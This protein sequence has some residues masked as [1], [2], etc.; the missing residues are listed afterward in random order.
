MKIKLE[1]IHTQPQNPTAASLPLFLSA[2]ASRP[3]LFLSATGPT[4]YPRRRQPGV[5]NHRVLRL[6]FQS[7]LP[8]PTPV[9]TP[10]AAV[11]ERPYEPGKTLADTKTWTSL[12]GRRA[13]RLSCKVNET[14][15]SYGP[16][17]TAI[18]VDDDNIPCI[19]EVEPASWGL[20][21]SK[22]RS[23]PSTATYCCGRSFAR[24]PPR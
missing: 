19:I 8:L 24:R 5:E 3:I 11:L 2:P 12:T 6:A 20:K 1:S 23:Y 4:P 13:S 7:P 17:R 21:D 18:F 22:A 14:E 9:R 16:K 15:Y 10:Y